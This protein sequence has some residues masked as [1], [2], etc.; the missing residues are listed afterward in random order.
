MKKII[1]FGVLVLA[2]FIVFSA[3]A[4]AQQRLSSSPR[5]FQ[6]FFAKFRAAVEKSE[7]QQVA[8]MTRFP[9]KYAFD[10]GDEGTMTKRQFIKQ[11]KRTFGNSP[12][13]SLPGKNPLFSRD[14][15]NYIVSTDDASHFIFVKSGAGFKFIAYLVEP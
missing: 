5:A 12:R 1:L 13:E 9:F 7:R 15:S 2:H 3:A 4:S 8:A 14:G 11:F 10:A 6:T